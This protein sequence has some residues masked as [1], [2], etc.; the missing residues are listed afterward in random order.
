M[1]AADDY[2]R[3]IQPGA[4]EKTRYEQ[5]GIVSMVD[6]GGKLILEQRGERSI[7]PGPIV[8]RKGL[9]IDRIMPLLSKVF[10]SWDYRHGTYY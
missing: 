5:G 7:Q 3:G 4:D 9:D 6:A 8:I 2:A 10:M 1:I